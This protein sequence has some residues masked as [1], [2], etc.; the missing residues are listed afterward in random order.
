MMRAQQHS[1]CSPNLGWLLAAFAALI[2]M[3]QS[4]RLHSLTSC[5]AAAAA[6]H[7]AVARAQHENAA[8]GMANITA[9]LPPAASA[10][11]ASQSA[12]DALS[13]SSSSQTVAAVSA[14]APAAAAA[15]PFRD[16]AEPRPR[17]LVVTA[18]QP[19]ECST[20]AAQWLGSRAMRNRMQ[21][22]QAHGYQLYW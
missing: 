8:L 17:L 3:V 21:Y 7:A 10:A 22:A 14:P 13:S 6:T 4:L 15:A 9:A 20:A 11:L 5:N 2:V 18:E 16:A 19:T 12:G 1:S